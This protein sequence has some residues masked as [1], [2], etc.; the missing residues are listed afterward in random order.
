MAGPGRSPG[1]SP[2]GGGELSGGGRGR[3]TRVGV[4]PELT[5]FTSVTAEVVV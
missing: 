4:D 2:G 3:G 5:V 1:R